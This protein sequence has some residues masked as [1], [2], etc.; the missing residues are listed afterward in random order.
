MLRWHREGS[1]TFG[2]RRSFD[3][4]PLSDCMSELVDSDVVFRGS[5]TCE[6]SDGSRVAEYF[7]LPRRKGGFVMF[8]VQSNLKTAQERD[9]SFRQAALVAVSQ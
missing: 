6:D 3:A 4:P 1:R 2:G 7:I 5:V 8:S 9:V